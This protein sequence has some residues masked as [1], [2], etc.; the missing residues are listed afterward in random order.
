MS[1]RFLLIVFFFYISISVF[2]QF[3]YRI[4]ANIL[5]KTRLLDST[6]QISKGQLYYDVNYQKIVFEFQFPRKETYVL[7]DTTM[8]IFENLKL[9]TT[10]FNYLI[11]EQSFF[12]Y[13]LSGK[14]SDYGLNESN[15]SATDFEKKNDMVITTWEP[16]EN[17]QSILS[18]ILV[19]TKNKEL[20]SVTMVDDKG[21]VVNRQ[22]LKN[23]QVIDGLEIPTEILVATYLTEGTMY[24]IITLSNVTL[25]EE[26]NNDQYNYGL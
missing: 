19:A 10:S 20:Y 26:G 6:F 9:K 5:T 7:F 13:I 21:K 11:P 4:N 14:I 1:K 3:A 8:Y 25:N 23:Y 17:L 2:P 18:K 12:H 24:Q 16:P 22:I 15:F